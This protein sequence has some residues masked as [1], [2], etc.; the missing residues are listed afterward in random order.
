MQFTLEIGWLR[1]QIKTIN[2]EIHRFQ[3]NGVTKVSQ[4]KVVYQVLTGQ[5][6]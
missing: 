2:L 6:I 4:V 3:I 1:L 5:P